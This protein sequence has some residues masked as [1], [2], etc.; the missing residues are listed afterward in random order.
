MGGKQGRLQKML[1]Q[2]AFDPS[3]NEETRL[4]K[5]LLILSCG[6]MNFG[7]VVWLAIYWAMD[8][9]F[10]TTV[11][12][13][14]Q[15]ISI[16]SLVIFLTGRNFNHFRF[17]QL[18]LFLFV[19]FV[20]Q[21]SIGNY[22]TSSGVVLWAFLAPV[23]A[24]VFY[25]WRESIPWFIAYIVLNVL[26]GFFDYY[27]VFGYENG[28]PLKTIAVFFGLNFVVI[29]SI[30][31]M[32]IRFFVQQ[33]EAIRKNLSEEHEL[34]VLEQL[35]SE[36]L[37]HNMLPAHIAERLKHSSATIA[38]GHTDVTVIF[39]DIVNFTRLTE[40]MYPK[41]LVALLNHLFS[42]FD[43][44][45]EKYSLEKIKTIG[46]AYMA[47]GGLNNNYSDYVA[48]VASMALEIRSVVAR[49][50]EFTQY[51][52]NVRI[53]ISTGPVMGGV[54]G[55]KR[56]IY[57]LWGDTVNIAS[58]LSSEGPPG[59]IQVD[60]LTYNRLCN[61]YQF[62]G[63]HKIVIKGKGEITMYS[64]KERSRPGLRDPAMPAALTS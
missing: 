21:W 26:S 14:Y 3:D 19:P 57:D 53:G 16:T 8:I 33:Q 41:Q 55:T 39:I 34:L 2:R 7:V 12:L 62:Q 49:E 20:M 44:L 54:V 59:D 4:K 13:T 5:N 48:A 9:N 42:R 24:V 27:L 6:L 17:I 23:G 18:S 52:M 51:R 47:V 38:D 37:L 1:E 63:P 31:Y 15:L 30:I 58:R 64:L 35:K 25:G 10:S 29:S 50:P 60:T 28:M 45:V 11:P 43:A 61:F 22:V 40:Q 32:L 46:D 56:F 36:R